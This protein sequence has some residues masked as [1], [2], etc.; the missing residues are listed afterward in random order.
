MTRR[1]LRRL[2]ESGPCG[3]ALALAERL[4]SS[5]ACILRVLTYHRVDE[6]GSFARQLE[7]LTLRYHMVSIPRVLAAIDGGPRLPPRA[8]LL[9]FDDAYR[10]FAEVAWPIL[11]RHGFPAAL[12]V[13]TAYPDGR[14]TR[15]WWDR[16]EQAFARTACRTALA[17]PVGTLALGTAAERARAHALVKR[18]VKD[19]EHARTLALTDELCAALGVAPEEHEVLG[20]DELRALARQGVTLGAHTRT[21]PRLDRIPRAQARAELL[22]SVSDLEREVPGQPRVLA[23]PDGRFD[24]ELVALVR[25]AGVELAFTTRRGTNDLERSDR[26]RLRRIHV[27][28]CD[29]VDVLRAK[30][31]LSAAR[32]ESATRL[33]DPPSSDER[34]TERANRREHRRSQIVLRALDAALTARLRPDAQPLERLRRATSPRTAHYERVG[35]VLRLAL[36]TAPVLAQGLE[37]ALLD[38]A[39][40][41]LRARRIELAGFGSGATVFRLEREGAAAPA[42]ALKIYRRTLG[43]APAHLALSARRY[44]ERYRRLCASFGESV[45]PAEFLVVHAPLRSVPAVACIQPWLGGRLH[46]L[47]GLEDR[48][49][50]DL[51][52]AHPGLEEQF[53][54]FA[55]R[56]LAWHARGTFP[57]LLGAANLLVAEERGRAHLW[58]ID[59]GI[60]EP[61]DS[62]ASDEARLAIATLASRLES[63]LERIENVVVPG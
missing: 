60:F 41:P 51:L 49:L 13:P 53:A 27:D 23:Y 50:L 47:L 8:V 7:Y 31:V 57:D 14:E 44:R 5:R 18:H 11:A 24:D 9:T 32:L 37:R 52:R 1:V 30:L 12:F 61:S 20:W 45:L 48:A 35:Q 36:D 15:F 40:L 46:D 59:Y 26:L 10:S 55:R 21:H 39:R 38:S 28:A 63:L 56:A 16:L 3:R 58:L 29:S 25:A 19:L 33:L 34:R 4:D 22:G 42:L 2:A 43:R 6:A 17:T 54:A 62:P